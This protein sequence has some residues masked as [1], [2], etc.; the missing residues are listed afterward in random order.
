MRPYI[1]AVFD[2]DLAT[3]ASSRTGDVSAS[4]VILGL[5]IRQPDTGAGV[6][7]RLNSR[8]P[9]ARWSRNAVHNNLP[10]LVRRGYLRILREG[11]EPSLSLYEAT[12]EGVDHFGEWL[13]E[14]S[15]A[16]LALRDALRAK[17]ELCERG[18]LP[19]V[20]VAIREE[21]LTCDQ[22][23]AAAHARY[24]QAERL[25]RLG[26]GHDSDWTAKLQSALVADEALLWG[27]WAKRLQRLQEYCEE[28]VQDV[29]QPG[30][31]DV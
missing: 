25:E 18:D 13:R 22:E 19:A 1:I 28:L 17:L 11:A 23:Y 5:M 8:F 12:R 29:E 6:G 31:R 2:Y 26:T 9:H 7:L 16:P 15:H 24:K 10:G 27:Q 14:P 20:I 30:D 3:M 21:R 4:K